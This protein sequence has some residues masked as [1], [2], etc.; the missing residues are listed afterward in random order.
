MSGGTEKI[1][2][3]LGVGYVHDG[4]I[5]REITDGTNYSSDRISY[6]MNMD[7]NVTRSTLI[8]L[9]VGGVTNMEKRLSTAWNSSTVF[10]TIYQAPTIS[11]PAYYPECA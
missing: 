9:K 5:I 10:S 6:R 8:S 3:Y 2:Y 7:W 4:S 1:K 11:Y